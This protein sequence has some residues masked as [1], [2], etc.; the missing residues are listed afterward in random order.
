M[1]VCM[2]VCMYACMHV[3]MYVCTCTQHTHL[4]MNTFKAVKDIAAGQELFLRYLS[5]K[6]FQCRN[7]PRVNVDYAS[8]MWRPELQPLPCR[9][10]VD[11]TTGADGQHSFT[12][13]EAIPSGTVL[14]ISLCVEVSVIVVDQFPYLWDFVLTGETEN[15]HTGC[16]QT[17]ASSRVHTQTACVFAGEGEGNIGKHAERVL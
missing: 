17:S 3:F 16:Q 9:Q 15:E 7:I 10:N 11:P 5:A 14:E 4:H 1:Y 12:V 2:Y 6:Y 13:V 8:T